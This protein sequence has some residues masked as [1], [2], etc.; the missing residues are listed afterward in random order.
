[1]VAGDGFSFEF[2]EK[3]P[4]QCCLQASQVEKRGVH[5]G[6]HLYE[7][8]LKRNETNPQTWSIIKLGHH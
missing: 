8:A 5:E 1:M 2:S 3:T 4:S 6:E 7:L